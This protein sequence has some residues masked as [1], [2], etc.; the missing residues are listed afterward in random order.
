[1]RNKPLP[2][3]LKNSPNK[4]NFKGNKGSI[5]NSPENQERSKAEYMSKQKQPTGIN[6]AIVDSVVDNVVPSSA[7]EAVTMVGGMGLVKNLKKVGSKLY[8]AVKTAK[9]LKSGTYGDA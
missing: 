3:L 4:F 8:H 9:T 5:V 1:M 6:K 2:G 7:T